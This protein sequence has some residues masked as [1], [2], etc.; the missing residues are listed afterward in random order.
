MVDVIKKTNDITCEWL[1]AALHEN[2]VIR[3]AVSS[4]EIEPIGAGIGLM[5]DLC[6]LSLDYTSEE[7]APKSM[8]VKCAVQNDN[9]NVARLLDFYNRETNFYNKIGNACPL[10][11]PDSYFGAVNQDTYDFVILLEDLGDVSTRDQLVGASRDEAF[12]AVEN[13]AEMHA[14]WWDKVSAP[15]DD[16]MYDFMCAEESERLKQL[17]YMPGLEPAIEKFE[18]SFNEEMKQVCRRVGERY[19]EFW[20][21]GLTQVDTFIHGDYRQ[22][23][24]IYREDSVDAVVMD[25]QIS[26]KGKGIFDVAYFMC[27][28]L[29]SNLRM[30]IEREIL[31]M[32][33]G[34]LKEW[35]VTD[36]GIDQCWQDYRLVIL[37]CLIYPITVCG[38]L[39]MAN[40][41]GRALGKSMLER[42]LTAISDL[43]CQQLVL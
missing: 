22:D 28:S 37:G 30:E 4:V 33:V 10:N 35:G 20:A 43:G 14:K 7:S 21:T 23:N 29:A 17:V 32:Y 26:G 2:G 40:E 8:V 41:R 11:V 6:R 42:N 15:E 1:T 38:T 16:W 9:I 13:L 36:Y 34:K 31:E 24:M 12:R 5:S 39:D 27:Q 25:W 3:S 19:S 18:S